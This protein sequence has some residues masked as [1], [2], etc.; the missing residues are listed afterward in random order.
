MY[1]L[2]EGFIFHIPCQSDHDNCSQDHVVK[3]HFLQIYPF[4]CGE[5]NSGKYKASLSLSG[6]EEAR[7]KEVHLHSRKAEE[8]TQNKYIFR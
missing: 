5:G 1:Y 3:W 8:T 4:L 7:N 6:K 2:V